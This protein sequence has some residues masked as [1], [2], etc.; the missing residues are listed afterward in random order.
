[1][2][3]IDIRRPHDMSMKD[4]RAA[5][6]KMAAHL[7]RKFGLKGDWE[8]DTLHFDR[9]GVQGSLHLMPKHLKLTVTLGFLLKMM[10]GSIEQA[11]DEELD[12]LFAEHGKAGEKKPA[13]GKAD[14]AATAKKPA[15]RKKSA[16]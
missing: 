8:G 15:A 1:M 14:R 6:E 5:A 3:D 16:P 9:P 12:K 7:G 11:V 10:R 4:A 2:A 13:A